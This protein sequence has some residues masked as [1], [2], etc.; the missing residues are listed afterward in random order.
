[1]ICGKI[2]IFL[3]INLFIFG[4]LG[5]FLFIDTSQAIG[6]II[7]VDDSNTAGPWNGTVNFPYKTI[8]EAVTAANPGDFLR[9]FSGN[10]Y[11]KIVITKDLTIAGE[12][13][14]A[15]VIIGDGNGHVVNSYGTYDKEI[16]VIFKNFTIRNAGGSGFDCMTFSYITDGEIS[17]NKILNSLEGEGISID[18]CNAVIIRD[19]TITNNKVK[20]ISITAS[21]NNIIQ[22][23][24][25]QYNQK[26]I[27]LDSYSM[28]NQLTGNTI[29]DNT[30][31]GVYV[32]Q[33]SNN[34]FSCNVFVGNDQNAQDLSTNFWSV[35][36]QGNYWDDYN[37]Y[38]NNSDGIGD[39]PYTI[40]GGANLDNYPLGY[41]KQPGQ[42]GGGNQ[43]P[44]AVSLSISKNP[45]LKNESI[46]FYGQGTDVDGTIIGYH[47]R[48]SLDGSLSTQQSFSTSKL[49]LGTHIIYFKVMDNAGA[50]S[51]E[52]TASLTINPSVNLKPVAF[53]D[54]ITPNPAKQGEPIIFRGHGTDEDDGIIAYKWLSTKDG[55]ISTASS[56]ITSNLSRG[57]HTV[58]FQVKDATEWSS[59][60]TAT[61]TIERNPSSG[62]MDNQVPF[63]HAGGPYHGRVNEAI[64]FNGSQSYDEEGSIVG[65][66]N[67]GDNTSGTGLS[68]THVY[69]SPGTYTV[70][71][72]V[73]DEDGESATASTQAIVVQS[74]SQPRDAEGFSFLDF[75]IPFPI[76]MVIALLL[77][78]G[79]FIGFLFKMK[80][81]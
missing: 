46:T 59:Q 45:A 61:L 40:P 34:V 29:R 10:Y 63:A 19:N 69:T 28:N 73:V 31:F 18:H 38:D 17:N 39:T 71:L 62:N 77:M 57:T 36:G 25:I 75:E 79:I 20:G 72:T 14:D 22:N 41:F 7:Y 15:T 64:R 13:K 67:F 27:Q 43:I 55:V 35:N 16:Q 74:S 78:I 33:S 8:Q 65:Y 48:S 56:F 52:K 50:W 60:V 23:N 5:N 4:F 58:Y 51:T 70:T 30:Q 32:T 21:G 1:M 47:W 44:T 80:Q 26:G 12:N 11:E 42:S 49:A 81:R 66:W 6:A 54:Q 76:L 53:I 37:K 24:L 2:S 68:T 3:I 9:V